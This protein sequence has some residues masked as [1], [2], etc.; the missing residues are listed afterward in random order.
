MDDKATIPRITELPPTLASQIAA[1]EV[2]ERPAAVVKELLDNSI[3]AGADEVTVT[4]MEG[5]H[6]LIA[7]S[8]NGHGIHPDDMELALRRHSTSKLNTQSD[9]DCITSLGFRG[10]ALASIAA[11]SSFL[12][13][14]SSAAT[15]TAWSLS[16]D[17][18]SGH[19][20]LKPA[21]RARGTTVEAAD[22]FQ[23]TPARRKFMRSQS[24]EFLHISEVVK[25]VACS[26]F[27]IG[28]RLAHNGKAVLRYRACADNME[29]RVE[30]VFGRRFATQSIPVSYTSRG[31]KL[32][33]WLG[34][35]ELSRSQSDRQFCFVNGRAVRDRKILHAVRSAYADTLPAGRYPTCLLHLDLDPAV[36]DINVHPT[37]SE[38][39]F[40]DSRV[41]HDFIHISL[42]DALKAVA[43]LG[44]HE[45]GEA[46]TENRLHS[47]AQR[48]VYQPPLQVRE[49]SLFYQNLTPGGPQEDL[50]AKAAG[51]GIPRLAL[52]PGLAVAQRNEDLVLLNC[53]ALSAYVLRYRLRQDYL[54]ESV[55]R[56]PLL[57]P[58]HID[59]G[60]RRVDMAEQYAELLDTV[61]LS[62]RVVAEHLVS[63]REIPVLLEAVDV[64]SMVSAVL[65]ALPAQPASGDPAEQLLAIMA[66]SLED[67]VERPT[68]AMLEGLLADLD[69]TDIDTTQKHHQGLWRTVSP[70]KLITLINE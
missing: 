29:E 30:E 8:D 66:G 56:R 10:E 39:R 38:I 70:D 16:F 65:D 59:V 19:A 35:G 18:V 22:I 50:L 51:L 49:A 32:W 24:T 54:H 37:K 23:A 42:R 33:G 13:V 5:G 55:P 4:V 67:S 47:Y 25:R 40:R 11:V 61:G 27:N 41:V 52:T 9:L 63:V 46:G 2:I 60:R 17:P 62:L 34:A 15:A 43:A 68:N 21:A 28:F 57:V 31:M 6:K 1:G 36:T 7:V 58:V 14:S 3:D 48:Q 20:A 45:E 12:L 26:R 53:H 69:K 44:L 64:K